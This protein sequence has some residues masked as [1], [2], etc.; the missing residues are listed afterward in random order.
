MI[1]MRVQRMRREVSQVRRVSPREKI[2]EIWKLQMKII[3]RTDER[4]VGTTYQVRIDWSCRVDDPRLRSPPHCSNKFSLFSPSVPTDKPVRWTDE[5]RRKDD[6][7][8]H[9]F[10]SHW[11]WLI[12]ASTSGV[13]ESCRP[14][15]EPSDGQNWRRCET[16]RWANRTCWKCP[17]RTSIHNER[18]SPSRLT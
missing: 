5:R 14:C 15:R 11:L 12:V 2:Y 3:E 1:F 7:L 4:S 10:V 9:R 13:V 18:P 6:L 16:T 17:K 8:H